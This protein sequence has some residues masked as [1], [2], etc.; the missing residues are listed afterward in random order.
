MTE[1]IMQK[2][3]LPDGR[4]K[5]D[6]IGKN[7]PRNFLGLAADINLKKP[8]EEDSYDQMV[9]APILK[10]LADQNSLI[11][12]AKALPKEGKIVLGL[13][14]KS[15]HLVS[16]PDGL[17]LSFIF[18]DQSIEISE[19]SNQVISVYEQ[20]RKDIEANWSVNNQVEQQTINDQTE[21]LLEKKGNSPLGSPSVEKSLPVEVIDGLVQTDLNQAAVERL[22]QNPRDIQADW[23]GSNWFFVLLVGLF[24]LLAAGIV[25]YRQKV[26][27]K[28][29][30]RSAVSPG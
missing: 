26:T 19:I 21:N 17:L 3:R 20:G 18:D 24:A 30:I 25:Y 13:T 7:L 29:P 1:I 5:L 10:D 8:F 28:P 22:L 15:D 14:L 11:D 16:L 4:V 6:L 9:L 12:L 2:N 27:P 23:L